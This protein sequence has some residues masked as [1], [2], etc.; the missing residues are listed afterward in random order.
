[1]HLINILMKK[2]FQLRSISWQAT[3]VSFP[4]SDTWPKGIPP[5]GR[6]TWEDRDLDVACCAKELD[7]E[8]SVVL[9]EFR[10]LVGEN[11]TPVCVGEP[12]RCSA[13]SHC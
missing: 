11:P 1:M 9:T 3:G 12:W 13:P 4:K 2:S 6:L 5:L 8:V 10:K 7:P